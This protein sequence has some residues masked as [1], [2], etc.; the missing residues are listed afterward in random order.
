VK[1][2]VQLSG[3]GLTASILRSK[4]RSVWG[5]NILGGLAQI[6]KQLLSKEGR[7]GGRK[8]GRKER[9]VRGESVGKTYE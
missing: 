9:E 8:E 1:Q 6:E 5:M 4:G 2:G 7:K 3:K